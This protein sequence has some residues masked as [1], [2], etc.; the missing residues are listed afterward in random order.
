MERAASESRLSLSLGSLI[1]RTKTRLK[2]TIFGKFY[3]K[4]IWG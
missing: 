4:L 1:S 2:L 3:P